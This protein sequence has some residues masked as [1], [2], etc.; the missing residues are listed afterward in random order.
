[1]CDDRAMTVAALERSP[2]RI[3]DGA[4]F[5][6]LATDLERTVEE[7]ARELVERA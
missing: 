7:L 5:E 4:H 1:M 6:V 3:V 2:A